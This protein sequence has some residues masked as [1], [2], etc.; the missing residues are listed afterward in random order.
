MRKVQLIHRAVRLCASL[1]QSCWKVLLAIYTRDSEMHLVFDTFGFKEFCNTVFKNVP[2]AIVCL[3][4]HAKFLSE[5]RA[6]IVLMW[7]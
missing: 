3:F 1:R 7:S 6:R 5:S 4:L 2:C